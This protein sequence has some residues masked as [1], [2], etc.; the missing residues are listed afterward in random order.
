M[1]EILE[2]IESLILEAKSG[3]GQKI[4][5]NSLKKNKKIKLNYN[6]YNDLIEYC[7]KYNTDV[8]SILSEYIS[9]NNAYYIDEEY[10][11][12]K[13]KD[14]ILNKY[15]D[16]DSI[17][18]PYIKSENILMFK[19]FIFSGYSK[20]DGHPIYKY[21]GND[22]KTDIHTIKSN[23]K[24]TNTNQPMYDRDMIPSVSLGIEIENGDIINEKD[25]ES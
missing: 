1:K 14:I 3:K 17:F 21:I 15:K 13:E 23:T 12:E 24:L 20:V 16:R 10:D 18:T 11:I 25:T 19:N 2:K 7:E 8:N 4:P 22:F 6:V 9:N 5:K